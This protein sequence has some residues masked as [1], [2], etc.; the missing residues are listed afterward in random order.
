MRDTKT[1]ELH[2]IEGPIELKQ[3]T[4]LFMRY[5]RVHAKLEGRW[6]CIYP[7]KHDKKRIA[8]VELSRQ[9]V[10]IVHSRNTKE[11]QKYPLRIKLHTKGGIMK[12]LQWFFRTNTISARNHWIDAISD[13][14]AMI[15]SEKTAD[16]LRKLIVPYTQYED[17]VIAMKASMI[18]TRK[19]IKGIVLMECFTGKEAVQFLMARHYVNS[20]EDAVSMGQSIMDAELLHHIGYQS[21]FAN[22]K[23]S[24][25]FTPRFGDDYQMLKRGAIDKNV[26]WKYIAFSN[27]KNDNNRNSVPAESLHAISVPVL[28]AIRHEVPVQEALLQEAL[29]QEAPMQEALMQEAPKSY[30]IKRSSR[31]SAVLLKTDLLAPPCSR[32]TD[33]GCAPKDANE[34]PYD[35]EHVPSIQWPVAPHAANE[36]KREKIV[37]TFFSLSA[38]LPSDTLKEI[39]HLMNEFQLPSTSATMTVGLLYSEQWRILNTRNM[40]DL[41]SGSLVPRH[42]ALAPFAMA[43]A[44]PLVCRNTA[45]DIRFKFHPLKESVG[46]Y[47]AIPLVFGSGITVG[48]LEVMDTIPCSDCGNLAAVLEP[49]G[50]EIAASL[51]NH[52]IQSHAIP[53]Q[54]NVREYAEESSHEMEMI[55]EEQ[56]EMEMEMDSSL[57]MTR[58]SDDSF[59]LEYLSHKME[60]AN[61]KIWSLHHTPPSTPIPILGSSH[62]YD[63]VSYDEDDDD[64]VD[65]LIMTAEEAEAFRA[66]RNEA[67]MFQYAEEVLNLAEK[68]TPHRRLDSNRNDDRI[69]ALSQQLKQLETLLRTSISERRHSLS[70]PTA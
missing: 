48:L 41:P 34:L 31:Q 42:Q 37:S 14:I 39:Q 30:S 29:M 10:Q 5:Q 56:P 17:T 65:E 19:T 38:P 28:K 8:A 49:M 13:N 22:N 33:N 11:M 59:N 62:S 60:M 20:I 40:Y 3:G 57:E 66:S 55:S 35:M 7:N 36:S 9:W 58:D 67:A 4:G 43:A 51:Q 26:V 12:P 61:E 6:L 24:Y 32:C 2:A 53:E 18:F 21:Q 52:I 64:F 27:N 54:S 70:P 1:T 15:S 25:R 16:C 46:F 63:T 50:K 69:D 23:E 47:M 68:H 44:G 45:E